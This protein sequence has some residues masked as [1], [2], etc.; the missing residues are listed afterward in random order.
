MIRGENLTKIYKTKRR[1]SSGALDNISFTLPDKGLVFIIGKSGSGKSTLLNMIGGLDKITSGDVCCFGNSLAKMSARDLE[2]YR[3]TLVGFIFQDFHLIDDLTIYDNIKLALDLQNIHDDAAIYEALKKVDLEGYENRYPREISGG[4]KQRVAVARVLVKDPKIILADEPTGNLDSKTTTQIIQLLKKISKE[5][6]VV[7]V[8]HSL[9]DAYEYADRILELSEG[10]IL[11]DLDRDED[12]S[13]N[14]VIQDGVLTIPLIKK[15]NETELDRIDTALSTGQVKKL[16]Q[17]D[18]KFKPATEPEYR[19]NPIRLLKKTLSLKN[20]LK[21]CWKFSKGHTL[22]SLSSSVIAACLVIILILCQTMIFFDHGK[23]LANE[24][25]RSGMDTVALKKT[26]MDGYINLDRAVTY[27]TEAEEEEIRQKVDTGKVYRLTN[28]GIGIHGFGSLMW[29]S[30]IGYVPFEGEYIAFSLGNLECDEAFLAKK[31]GKDGKLDIYTGDVEYKKS[32]I[33][34]TD[35]VADAIIALGDLGAGTYDDILGDYSIYKPNSQGERHYQQAYI[36][37]VIQ[38]GYEERY[39]PVLSFMQNK[40][41]AKED[42]PKDDPLFIEFYDEVA[43]YLGIT[44]SFEANF[45]EAVAEDLTWNFLF[46]NNLKVDDVPVTEKVSSFYGKVDYLLDMELAYD[47]V[48]IDYRL[49]NELMDVNY[50]KEQWEKIP[51]QRVQVKRSHLV[52]VEDKAPMVDM[53]VTLRPASIGDGKIVVFSKELM[54]EVVG[55][56]FVCTDLYFDGV[57]DMTIITQISDAYDMS[58]NSLALGA[59]ISMSYTVRVFEGFFKLIFLVLCGA[60][61]LILMR[62]GLRIVK[63]RMYEIGV[64]KALG[65]K[66]RSFVLIFGLQVVFL[67][68]LICLFSFAGMNVFMD[69]A[70]DILISSYQAMIDSYVVIDMQLLLVDPKLALADAG[71]VM[72]LSLLAT[73]TPII[74]LNRV[75]P[76]NIIKAKE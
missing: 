45:I 76:I 46:F 51:P 3:N 23:V 58:P 70:N 6:L 71:L 1:E 74:F 27:L 32:G 62:Y 17:N 41:L 64:I 38:T 59:M 65:G 54:Q 2:N 52:D 15:L 42:F 29:E 63:D 8:S 68:V 69:I 61:A 72:L 9:L 7:V 25:M 28:Y 31:Y 40:Q 18:S 66:T 57:E 75:K 49:C 13:E 20:Q 50:T 36:N 24:L 37:G 39:A 30:G 56:Q 48:V 16:K 55:K 4:Q 53:Q 35:Y 22:Q 21:L 14:V 67:G 26:A 73:V 5:K 44:Y 10:K 60:T 34:I 43:Q 33:Y 47:E 19:I 12:Y 11:N